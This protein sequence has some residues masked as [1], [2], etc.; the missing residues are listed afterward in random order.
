[1]TDPSSAPGP[2]DPRTGGR[3]ITGDQAWVRLPSSPSLSL[4]SGGG[5]VRGI[6]DAFA[7]V[8]ATGTATLRMPIPAT[9]GRGDVLPDLALEYDAGAGNGLFGVG[10]SVSLPKITRKTSRSVPAYDGTDTFLL[11]GAELVRA[12][13][14]DVAEAPAVPYV[15]SDDGH[16][17]ERFRPR[18]EGA[19]TRVERWTDELSGE[20]HW[21]TISRASVTSVFG[22]SAGCRVADPDD[23]RR[24]FGWLIEE[25]HDDLGNVVAFDYAREDLA[26]IEGAP[27]SEAHR[28][29]RPQAERHLKRIRYGNAAPGIAD[30]W[31]FEVVLDY[32]D[33]DPDLPTP[34]PDRPWSRRLD[35]FSGYRAGFELRTQRLCRRVLMFHTHPALGPQPR[36][37]RSVDLTYDEDPVLSRLVAITQVGY[38]RDTDDGPYLP[39]AMPASRF[40][41][42]P[43]TLDR[44][45]R[46]LP[47]SGPQGLGPGLVD[48][49]DLIDLDGEGVPGILS[50]AAGTWWYRTNLG[51]GR[52]APPVVVAESPTITDRADQ[53]ALVDVTG[54]GLPDVLV[55]DRD[56]AGYSA[57]DVPGW[58]P[59]RAFASVPSVDLAAS[60][61]RMVD[62]TGDGRADILRDGVEGLWW[63][64]SLGTRGFGAAAAVTSAL[65]G[66]SEP[67]PGPALVLADAEHVV[68]LADMSGD[69]L[70][71]LVHIR[72]GRVVYHPNL[73]H[74]RFGTPVTMDD[75]PV[76][77]SREG[78]DATRVRLADV[79]GS[80]M[81]DLLYWDGSGVRMWANRAGNGLG[82]ETPLA[83]FP[84]SAPPVDVR[85]ADL[86]GNGTASVVWSSPFDNEPPRY[87][88]PLPAKPY[89]IRTVENG[90]GLRRTFV[91]A[92]STFFS[93]A[94]RA[95]GRPWSTRLPF[96]VQVLASVETEDAVAGTTQVTRFSYRHGRYDSVEREFAGFGRVDQWDA[97]T[98]DGP[99]PTPVDDLVTPP[100]HTIT[101]FHTGASPT[102]PTARLYA[103]EYYPADPDAGV[104]PDAVLEGVWT[105]EDLRY[106]ARAL[107]GSVLRQEL[108]A[109][110]G[111]DELTRERAR[112]PFSTS[113]R[114]YLLRLHQRA[115]EDRVGVV[116][117]HPREAL[118]QHYERVPT[119]PRTSHRLTL[120]IDSDG[121]ARRTLEIGYPRRPGVAAEAEQ[122]VTHAVLVEADLV[123]VDAPRDHRCG[124]ST[125]LRG[126]E[127]LGLDGA[128]GPLAFDTVL[129]LLA[130]APEIAFDADPP[131]GVAKRLVERVRTLYTADD[132][133]TELPFGEHTA[134]GLVH[135]QLAQAFT[136]AHVR[137]VLG[138]DVT[139]AML[140][141]EAGYVAVD[142]AWW[143]PT[144]SNR[145]DPARFYLPVDFTDPF[146]RVQSLTYDPLSLVVTQVVDPL[147]NAVTVEL[148]W[149]RLKPASTTDVNGNRTSVRFDPHGRVVAVAVMGKD[150][151]PDPT[152]RGDTLDAPTQ[153]FVYRSRE[154]VDHGRPVAV[155]TE[156]REEHGVDRWLSSTD[157]LDGSGRVL[158]TKARA[159]P[160]PAPLRDAA[161]VL[162]RDAAGALVQG[163]VDPRWVGSGRTVYDAK[164]RPVKQ[165]EPFFSATR[166]FE[167]EAD[168]VDWGVSSVIRYDATGRPVRTDHPDGTWS[169]VEIGP[170][171]LSQWDTSDTVADSDWATQRAGLPASDPRHRA[172]Q[173][174]L[175][176][177]GTPLR[178]VN[179]ALGR[180][181]LT[182]ADNG[183]AGT[184][185][186]RVGFNGRNDAVT[187]TDGRG[188][189]AMRVDWGM[190]SQK[191]RIRRL[192]AGDRRLLVDAASRP[193]REWDGAGLLRRHVYDAVGRRTHTFAS[194]PGG[195]VLSVLT[196]YGESHPQAA[197]LNLRGR[198]FLAL[199]AAG[200]VEHEDFDFK[201]NLLRSTRRVSRAYRTDTDWSALAGADASTVAALAEPLLEADVYP[202][203]ATYDARNRAIS[204]TQPDGTER[205]AQY[206]VG[207]LLERVDVRLRGGAAWT[208]FLSELDHNA[209]G[210]LLS[211]THGNGAVTAYAYKP[212]TF[213]LSRVRTTI[214]PA[215]LQDLGYTYDALGNV[216]EIRDDAQQTQFF[217]NAVVEPHRQFEYDAVSRLV[218]ADGRERAR[219]QVDA[220]TPAPYP[221]PHPNDGAAVQRYSERYTYDDAGNILSVVHAAPSAGWT[222]RHVHDPGSNRLQATSLPGD[223][224]G[225]ASGLYGYDEHG[226]TTSMP[227]LSSLVWDRQDRLRE[228]DLGGG[229]RAYHVYDLAGVRVR[230]VIEQ[231]GAPVEERVSIGAFE[232]YRR[233][234]GAGAV[235]FVRETIHV[236][237]L[238][239]TAVVE[240]T[241]V[242]AGPVQPP[243]TRIRYQHDDHLDSVCLETDES[244]AP[245]SYEEFYPFGSTAYYS[246]RAALAGSPKRFR[247]LGRERDEET[248]FQ[249]HRAR[250]YAPWLGRFVSFDPLELVLAG[251][252]GDPNGYAYGLNNPVTLSDPNGGLSWGKIIGFTAA[253]VIGVAVTVATGGIAVPIVAGAIG[254][255]VG[256]VAGEVTE[257]LVDHG[258]IVDPGRILVAGVSGAVLGGA[259]AA[260][261]PAVG[262]AVSKVVG[263]FL[264]T[265]LGQGAIAAVREIT[266]RVVAKPAGAAIAAGA[267]AL[268]SAVRSGVVALEELGEGVGTKMGGRFAENA[269]RQAEARAAQV[270]AAQAA[271]DGTKGSGVR[272][273]MRGDVEASTN[274]GEYYPN[275]EPQNQNIIETPNGPVAP[276][277]TPP[278]PLDPR[279]VARASGGKAFRRTDCAEIKLFGHALNTTTAESRGTVAIAQA[280][281]HGPV[282]MCPSCTANRYLFQGARPNLSLRTG[283]PGSDVPF[284]GAAGAA[285]PLVLPSDDPNRAIN[286][287]G[288]MFQLSVPF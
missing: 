160:G 187:S 47:L 39:D 104:L 225:V 283:P 11:S 97:T 258:K 186:H 199:D 203:A 257:Q 114:S 61:V 252:G 50:S 253:V 129:E 165:F 140:R 268:G 109:E 20:V 179:D 204:T 263:N 215:V 102:D 91:H 34:D 151:E 124:L 216:V 220:T 139:T 105:P 60:P 189:E 46:V 153:R 212:D 131:A 2:A 275:R 113:E 106:G 166:D 48:G 62:L 66:S 115:G 132:G 280:T 26:G 42:T 196:V 135:H 56:L 171:E 184:I 80:G 251:A 134:R 25:R 219:G 169:R 281:K 21:R 194:T 32:G 58:E 71:D 267:R 72:A 213:R 227:H 67:Q 108:Y 175:A 27:P 41:Y 68:F 158:Q 107:R 235:S 286:P 141:D 12:V 237:D 198:P 28:R 149:A 152:R 193:L 64:E 83:D 136:D 201:G 122:R 16:R 54:D 98:V 266:E 84:P 183:P 43:A 244:G 69:G 45:V 117:C 217:A 75:A 222:R 200:T 277:S 36:L 101:W 264:K 239:S 73:G 182:V 162:V 163:A 176:Y 241:L 148:D 40:S 247:Y 246:T 274:S 197:A 167:T 24:V 181:F 76:L 95:A 15:R 4:P 145:Y 144:G 7:T 272:S 206:N 112:H 233:F 195:E 63:H 59:F 207:A 256:G 155:D 168:L 23:E 35:P 208:P 78:F 250:H 52:F 6:D 133:V 265:E 13:A 10:W 119:D 279:P 9:P 231:N 261:A 3:S 177:A 143:F 211:V 287:A 170:W 161:G 70:S 248:G 221:L 229:G 210:Q 30:G 22:R 288:Q 17:V 180:T 192:D 240:T 236:G 238:R 278:P 130:V 156:S 87:V 218:R 226:N 209:K 81:A 146:G 82:P 55:M 138:G 88:Q 284:S 262:G 276:P 185:E 254:G 214:G 99:D 242:D 157:Y 92:P 94:D 74:G 103:S 1:M 178:M 164:G 243:Q 121:L 110:D 120:E 159:E 260:A 191:L 14:D 116:S 269:T 86:L 173:L 154:W 118:D 285:S 282:E 190:L 202:M 126:Y 8:P 271:A 224:A 123:T 31:V 5:A 90:L 19:L 249:L 38:D 85:V 230:K 96:P 147:G 37:V 29:G 57:R 111:T 44:T 255:M 33:H 93:L 128:A 49:H 223:P 270:E 100:V 228:V 273:T 89:L 18:V 65:A 174:S 232:V 125:E 79:D 127:V 77:E 137:A 188:N 142:D 53:R 205:R 245:I 234:D 172:G 259:F 150:G 51:G